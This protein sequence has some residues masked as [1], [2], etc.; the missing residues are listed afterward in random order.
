MILTEFHSIDTKV[1]N[2][3]NKAIN[4]FIKETVT[5]FRKYRE[6]RPITDDAEL[7]EILSIVKDLIAKYSVYESDSDIM[8]NGWTIDFAYGLARELM[9]EK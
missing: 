5:M 7:D 9:K 2:M 8:E 3:T 4:D 6:R 1:N